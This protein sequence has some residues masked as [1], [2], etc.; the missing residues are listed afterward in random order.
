VLLTPDG[1][2]R[3][4]ASEMGLLGS[5][6]HGVVRIAQNV[7]TL[8]YVAVKI[9]PTT[10]M[11]TAIKEVM[12]LTRL[13]HAHVVQ[14]LS[15]QVDMRMEKVYVLMELC[16]GGELF[17]RIAEC[18][19]LD[20]GEAKRYFV[21]ILAALSHCHD[22]K[23]YHRD[24]KPENI[25]LDAED[26]AKVADFGLAAVYRH[27]S[28]DATFLRH[29][30]VGSVM[31]AAPEVLTSTAGIGYDAACADM[32]SLGI[33]LFSMLSGTLPFQ[34]AAAS[35]C[36]RYAAV[37]RQG[38]QVMC[39][40][41]LSPSV[42]MLLGRM[43]DP[44]PKRRFTPGEALQ[45]EWLAEAL[46]MQLASPL[47]APG[48]A[49]PIMR[50]WTVSL[51]VPQGSRGA[52]TSE[53][54][55]FP[56][57]VCGGSSVGA[58]GASAY[59]SAVGGASSVGMGDAGDANA[60]SACAGDSGAGS[61]SS[62]AGGS[63]R[64]RA[65]EG[66]E[67][68]DTDCSSTGMAVCSGAGGGG[69]A[70]CSAASSGTRRGDMLPPPGLGGA[71]GGGSASPPSCDACASMGQ[72]RP[73]PATAG[74]PGA[75]G[76]A[77]GSQ[78]VATGTSPLAAVPTGVSAAGEAAAGAAPAAVSSGGGSFIPGLPL[79]GVLSEF[80]SQWGWGPLPQGTEQLL[81]DILQTLRSMGLQYT[82]QEQHAVDA[83]P[84]EALQHSAA[85]GMPSRLGEPPP[86][87]PLSDGTPM[88]R[89]TL[90][91]HF[92]TSQGSQSTGHSAQPEYSGPPGRL[93][94]CPS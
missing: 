67:P 4:D 57:M 93:P 27:V 72:T 52:I 63:K 86:E 47:G 5:G 12:A 40:E 75:C 23:V 85:L 49:T 39:P 3:I 92:S 1:Q 31:Y 15:V 94:A 73:G 70:E 64:K 56:P 43:L 7:H 13:N 16:Q 45:C 36:K 61:D 11:R 38:I 89:I 91:I 9:M 32:W 66:A 87:P 34:C 8:D 79:R 88:Q 65:E 14:L 54:E 44:D 71:I 51:G 68:A 18:G 80:V 10:V 62:A 50:S 59:S 29:T 6:A 58:G 42:T 35:R 33:I 82:L 28:D 41:H 60:G 69:T 26:N 83:P 78:A 19:G 17:D 37:L 90:K 21:Q 22:N 24:L 20:E 2:Y 77:G 55:A 30:K 81:R 84:S 74:L 76:C 53:S 48:S 46:P 25:L